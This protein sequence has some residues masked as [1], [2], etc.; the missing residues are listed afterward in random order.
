MR[1]ARSE[2]GETLIEVVISVMLLGIAVTMIILSVSTSADLSIGHRTLTQTDVALKRAAEAVK[3]QTYVASATP[4]YSLAGL[5][6][7]SGITVTVTKVVCL[8]GTSGSRDAAAATAGLCTATGTDLQLVTIQAKGS[9]T[10]ETTTV[11]KRK[12]S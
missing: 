12:L 7:P 8:S 1:A 5:T 6:W 3:A 4:T 10:D 2:E 11:V 9:D